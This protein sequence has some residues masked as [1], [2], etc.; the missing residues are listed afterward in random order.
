MPNLGVAIPYFS[1][2]HGDHMIPVVVFQVI[3]TSSQT[4]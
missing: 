2:S 3:W 1:G 4:Y